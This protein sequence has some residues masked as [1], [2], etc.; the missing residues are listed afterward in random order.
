VKPLHITASLRI[1]AKHKHMPGIPIDLAHDIIQ[2]LAKAKTRTRDDERLIED[3][4]ARTSLS[5]AELAKLTK[6]WP[7]EG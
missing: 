2:T 5:I 6:E 1:V 4:E 3:L 7:L